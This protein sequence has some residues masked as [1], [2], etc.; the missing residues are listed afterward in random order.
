MWKAAVR[1]FPLLQKR[2]VDGWA[3]LTKKKHAWSCR[4]KS[5]F[6]PDSF[7]FHF[8]FGCKLLGYVSRAVRSSVSWNYTK[9]T[10]P[11]SWENKN[12][13][14]QRPEQWTNWSISKSTN[15]LVLRGRVSQRRENHSGVKSSTVLRNK[16]GGGSAQ[17]SHW[18]RDTC[19]K[20]THSIV[21]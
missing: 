6:H 21:G 2:I 11:M 13:H 3:V 15:K 10:N 14:H 8:S 9:R 12:I 19:N 1:P 7:S 20:S 16:R 5:T 4:F 18:V 17:S